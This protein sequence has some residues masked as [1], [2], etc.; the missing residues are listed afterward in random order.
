MAERVNTEI[1]QMIA[2]NNEKEILPIPREEK[3]EG[4]L[5]LPAR[6][7]GKFC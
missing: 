2:E 6:W 7:M 5:K 3:A 1:V 4:S